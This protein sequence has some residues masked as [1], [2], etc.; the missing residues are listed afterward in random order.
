MA[1]FGFPRTTRDKELLGEDVHVCLMPQ[2][3]D[4]IAEELS[5]ITV[6]AGAVSDTFPLLRAMQ[7]AL[8]YGG[9]LKPSGPA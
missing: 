8:D 6:E 7:F 1:V 3:V 2:L 4:E 5:Y 9:Y